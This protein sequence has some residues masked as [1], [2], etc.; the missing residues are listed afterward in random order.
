MNK[1]LT[2]LLLAIGTVSH[3]PAQS[4]NDQQ[5]KH[6]ISQV[7]AKMKSMECD[8]VQTKQ[9]KMLNDKMVSKGRMYYQQ[10][11]KLRW[12]YES[13]Y[14]YVFVLND[15][16]VVLMNSSRSDVIDVNQNKMFREIVRIMMNTVVGNCLTDEKD[17]KVGID[18]SDLEYV[19][20]LFPLRKDLKQMFSKIVLHF[21]R[22]KKM[23]T[24]VVLL[25]KNGDTT[26]IE[27]KNVQSNVS[28]P[29]SM[30]TVN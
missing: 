24:Q 21:N 10:G 7:A 25:E 22:Q 5:V 17:F 9:L 20:T 3:V 14:R 2:I 12:E 27:L 11:N 23:I 16:K 15:S 26:V 4:I 13:P 19:A 18:T 8:F 1:I 28:I 30:F 29:N 6:E